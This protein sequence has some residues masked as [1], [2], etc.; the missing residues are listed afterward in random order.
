[1]V[2]DRLVLPRGPGVLDVSRHPDVSDLYLAAD[3]LVTDYSSTMFDFAVTG[4]PIVHFT[5]DLE[6]YRDDLRGFYF[7]LAEVAPGPLLATGTEVLGAA[8]RPRRG[9]AAA[10]GSLRPVPGARSAHLEDG[11]RHRPGHRPV[12]PAGHGRHRHRTTDLPRS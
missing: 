2:T 5:Y 4:E 11:A 12:L 10:P 6:H 1:M 8:R 7:D 9:H 3:V